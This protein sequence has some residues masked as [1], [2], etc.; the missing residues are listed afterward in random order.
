MELGGIRPGSPE[1]T[2]WF[3]LLFYIPAIAGGAFG[4]L[5]GYLTDRFGRQ[6]ILTASIMPRNDSQLKKMRL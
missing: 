6:R 3:G 5:G 2:F 4:L 1:F